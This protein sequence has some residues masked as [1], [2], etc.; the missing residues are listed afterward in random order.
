VTRRPARLVVVTGTGTEVGK[1]WFAA[2]TLAELRALGASVA[3]RK[4][5]QSFEAGTGA[6]DAELLASATGEDPAQVCPPHR[7]LALAMAPPMAA[8]ALGAPD[9]T[10]A[11]LAAEVH[12]PPDTDVGMVEG[13]GGP[14]SPLAAD[15]DTVD[16]VAALEPELVVLVADAG[17]GA[18]NAVLLAAAPFAGRDLVTALNRFDAADDVHRRNCSWLIERGRVDVVTDPRTL[19]AR[20][21][22]RRTVEA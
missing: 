6:T 3:A 1:T 2:A 5:V 7:S 21:Q 18:V 13:V 14:R 16:L 10:I 20:V 17:L 11:E 8:D 12:W 15:G 19:A 4:P 22:P 9:F